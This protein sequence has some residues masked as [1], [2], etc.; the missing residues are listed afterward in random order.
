MLIYTTIEQIIIQ[1]FE[2]AEMMYIF[3]ITYHLMVSRTHYIH[4]IPLS[5]KLWDFR[6]L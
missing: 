2:V 5:Y 1:M 6:F 4:L 3:P